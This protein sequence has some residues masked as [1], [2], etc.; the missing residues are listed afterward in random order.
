MVDT[1]EMNTNPQRK[2]DKDKGGS[3]NWEQ[4]KYN[5]FHDMYHAGIADIVDE[6]EG[7]GVWGLWITFGGHIHL[8]VF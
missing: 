2:E 5:F 1:T 7:E 4:F 6:E 3:M 8:L